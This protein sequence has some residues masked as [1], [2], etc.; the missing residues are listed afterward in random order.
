MPALTSSFLP[1]PNGLLQ[2]PRSSPR[3]AAP[4]W[5]SGPSSGAK[6]PN[7]AARDSILT[8]VDAMTRWFYG[9][10]FFFPRPLAEGNG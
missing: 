4:E 8:E 5:C 1:A 2:R 6:L 9:F 3:S 10:F 7:G